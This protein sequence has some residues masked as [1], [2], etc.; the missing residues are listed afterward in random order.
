[1]PQIGGHFKHSRGNC[2]QVRML[3]KYH[4]ELQF[5]TFNE[6]SIAYLTIM[7]Q[8]SIKISPIAMTSSEKIAQAN[9]RSSEQAKEGR[10]LKKTALGDY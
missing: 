4:Q 9:V 10:I 2:Y 5:E 3:Q 6:E 7:D 8:I 1:M